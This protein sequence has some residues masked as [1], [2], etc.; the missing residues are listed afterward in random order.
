MRDSEEA[1]SFEATVRRAFAQLTAEDL[2]RA[3]A[4]RGWTL[5]SPQ[6]FE[7][8]LLDHLAGASGRGDRRDCCLVDLVLAVELGGRLLAGT[9]CCDK[10]LDRLGGTCCDDPSLSRQ[11]H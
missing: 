7:Q 3:A 5:R 6:E 4:A 2:P 1:L 9:L 11:H 10:M 8:L